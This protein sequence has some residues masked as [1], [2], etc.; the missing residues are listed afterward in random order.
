MRAFAP[1]IALMFVIAFTLWIR[2]AGFHYYLGVGLGSA[3][4]LGRMF[5]YGGDR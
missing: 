4:G 2:D 5:P 3:F 1:W